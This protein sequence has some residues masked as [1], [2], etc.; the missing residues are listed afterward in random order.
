[1]KVA[2]ERFAVWGM[3]ALLLSGCIEQE[4]KISLRA[5][6]SG[7][8]VVERHLSDMESG[9]LQV[10][11]SK[12]IEFKTMAMERT[13]RDC[14]TDPSRK[15]E[16]SVYT[17][18]HLDE[19]LPELEGV[20]AMMPR[21]QIEGDR[22]VVFLRHEMNPYHGVSSK[23]QTNAFYNLEIEFP[24]PPESKMGE[25]Q[26][27]RVVWKADAKRLKELK[28]TDIGTLFFKCSVPASAIQLHLR[29][30]LVVSPDPDS[31]LFGT[32]RPLKRVST[33]RVAVPIMGK[34]QFYSKDQNGSAQFRLPVEPDRLPLSYENLQV[35]ELVIDGRKVKPTLHSL[36]SGVF[37]GK[38]ELGQD[39]PG[40]PVT[41]KF[42][43][44]FHSLETI[45]RIRVSMD[46]AIPAEVSQPA[47]FVDASQPTNSVL[48]IP[49]HIGKSIAVV[50]IDHAKWQ[51]AELTVASNLD[52]SEVSMVFLDTAYGLR[53]PA[54]GMRWIKLEQAYL[55]NKKEIRA[56]FGENEPVFIGKILYPHIP[57]TSF[58][59]VFSIIEKTTTEKLVLQEEEINVR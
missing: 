45:D 22:L 23:D 24:V 50:G 10:A 55:P 38:D 33:L 39:V 7:T 29:P 9:V 28:A 59:L 47:L 54:K 26:G 31:T 46:A 21:F 52:P 58:T 11:E 6:G 43:W 18:D 40:L 42:G 5:D 19:A 20:V 2:I 3:L 53:Y 16:R 30:R 4:V 36:S 8:V 44:N 17:F 1:M 48:Q 32:P 12:P 34:H 57:T 15:I 49:G 41:V 13:Y 35:E 51:S 14:A 25:V 27:N 56:I 37:F